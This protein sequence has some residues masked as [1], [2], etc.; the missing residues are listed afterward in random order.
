MRGLLFFLWL[1]V[2]HAQTIPEILSRVSEEAEVFRHNAKQMLSE[3]TLTQ[4]AVKAQPRFHPRIG[5]AAM[6]PPVQ[7][8]Q[9]REIRSE[10]SFGA[11]KDAPES[12]H[13]FREITAVDGREVSTV[14][15]ARHSLSLGISSA[16]DH[17][18]KRMLENF[19]KQGLATAVVDFGPLLLLFTKRQIDN[20]HFEA[21]G[22]E[23]IGADQVQV[24]VYRQTA[25]PNRMLIFQGRQALK[26]PI[27]GKIYARVPDG[28][29]LRITMT[30]RREQ[31]RHTYKDEATVDYVMNSHGF[32]AP[33]AVTHRGFFDDELVVE[34]NF[35]YTPF[36]KFGADA[37]IQFKLE[38]EPEKKQ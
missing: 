21:A 38:D 35:R 13:E 7:Q 3:E 18:R 23:R 33:A 31:S 11:L 6:K 26:E 19:Q 15:R 1:S 16:D 17:A 37:A 22:S 32:L 24:I 10:Y 14:Q 4:R 30:E 20:Y 36:R 9:T 8:W 5:A 28:L 2:A 12:L 34:D 25:G 29:P 27:Q